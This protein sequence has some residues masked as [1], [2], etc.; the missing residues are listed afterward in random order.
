MELKFIQMSKIVFLDDYYQGRTFFFFPFSL[1]K[2]L[3]TY[4]EIQRSNTVTL[5]KKI[6]D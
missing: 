6:N 2:K 4:L 5:E 1:Y 3:K